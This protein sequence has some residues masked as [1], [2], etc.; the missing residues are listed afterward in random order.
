[1]P[2]SPTSADR[3]PDWGVVALAMGGPARPEEV[4]PFLNRLFADPALIRA[5]L[6][7]LRRPLA[8]LIAR[9]R[10]PAA[11]RRYGLV[12]GSP[13]GDGTRA[14]ASALAAAL[15][16]DGVPVVPAFAYTEPGPADAVAAL[17]ARGVRRLLALPLYPQWSAT[18][19]GASVAALR[20]A[21]DPWSMPVVEAP[22]YPTLPGLIAPLVEATRAALADPPGATVLLTA[23]GL[24]ERYVRQGDPYVAQVEASAAAF[25]AALGGAVEVHLGYQSRLGPLRWVGPEVEDVVRDL[26]RRGARAL[27]VVPLT[28][29]CEHLE[30]RYDLD[31]GL[32]AAAWEAG[33]QHYHRVPAVGTDPAFIA[34]LA[35]LVRSAIPEA[36]P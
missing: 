10:A 17:A 4:E 14:Q 20:A 29:V 32:R 34:G 8:R 2:T 30:T 18:T 21:A 35:D 9:L 16:A 7:P 6:G 5:P 19:S 33:I 1:M 24:P 11:R 26:A 36:S 13:L 15:A 28:F 23:H 31:L 25:S 12:G 3:G 27:V 22:A